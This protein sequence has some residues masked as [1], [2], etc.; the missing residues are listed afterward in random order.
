MTSGIIRGGNYFI[1][2]SFLVTVT[3]HLKGNSLREGRFYVASRF[4]RQQSVV[5]EKQGMED[6]MAVSVEPK[7]EFPH[8]LLD[9]NPDRD[10]DSE[11]GLVNT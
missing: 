10:P 2:T 9:P 3:K 5:E 1:P 4:E 8:V 7:Y 11:P 6:E